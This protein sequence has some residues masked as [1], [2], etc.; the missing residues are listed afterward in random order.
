MIKK[1]LLF[2][3]SFSGLLGIFQIA[4]QGS[5]RASIYKGNQYFENGNYEKASSKFLD[6]VKE[7]NDDF[8]A[9]YNLGNSFYKRNKFNEAKSE[10]EK[11]QK[12]AKNNEDRLMAI[13]NLGN[14]EMQNKNYSK[15]ADLYKEALKQS[16]YN[17][18][19]RKNYQ[20]AKQKLKKQNKQSRQREGKEKSND[21]D[22]EQNNNSQ[23]LNNKGN[24]QQGGQ[25]NSNENDGKGRG[26]SHQ[27]PKSEER[28]LP[29]ELEE[30]IMKE[31]EKKEKET[32]RRIL[33]RQSYS[34][35]KSKEKD[36]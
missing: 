27:I 23:H 36:W 12:L 16:P 17:K 18:Y 15:A 31:V 11:A 14:A 32:A 7:R 24:E 35:P 9:H 26:K 33:N 6:V 29:K 8:S 4:A 19:V 30:S 5:Y 3:F 20:I 22:D 13:Y 2:L 21:G 34:M 25:D 1:T 28:H 10:Y